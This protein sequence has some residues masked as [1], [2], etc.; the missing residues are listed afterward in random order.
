[1]RCHRGGAK[2][3][4]VRPRPALIRLLA[5]LLLVQWGTAFGHCLRLS[6][7]AEALHLEICTPEGLRSLAV[8]ADQAPEP[9]ATGGVCP[10]CAG[11]GAAAVPPL[12]VGVAPPVVL[13]QAADPPPVPSPAAVP[14]PPRS[15]QPRAPPTS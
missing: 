10:A 6:A 8:P 3:A 13:A 7:P 14:T 5:V 1:M 9:T 4:V 12:P 15:C 11:P 2:D